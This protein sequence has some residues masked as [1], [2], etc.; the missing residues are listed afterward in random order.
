MRLLIITQKVDL[1][2]SALGFFH[3]WIEALAEKFAFI[4]VICLGKGHYNLPA[5]V[6]VYSLGKEEGLSRLKYIWRFYK[7]IWR[8]KRDYD[9]VFVH[10][11]PEY[12]LLGGLLWRF[13][14][15]VIGLWYVHKSVNIK[16]RIAEKLSHLIFSASRESFRLPSYK[17]RILGHAIDTDLFAPA[18]ERKGDFQRISLITAGRI[19]PIKDYETL[20]AA[21]EMLQKRGVEIEI[22]IIG[23]PVLDKDR[24]Y[25]K[26]LQRIIAE[27][28]LE[29]A[30]N[31]LGETPHHNIPDFLREA[32]IFI[33]MS[34]TGSVDKSVLEA[35]ACAVPVL[36][37]NEA[38]I[39]DVLGPYQNLLSYPAGNAGALTEKIIFLNQ[40]PLTERETLC[41]ELRGIVVLK[42]N[43]KQVIYNIYA[44]FN[45]LYVERHRN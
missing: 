43:M 20:I 31:F 25:L 9:V 5:N 30:I 35:M 45:D 7:Y 40:M 17:L 33:H 27:K 15:K 3:R 21:A 13:W 22:K 28:K 18:G 16:L 42:H 36:T 2:D 12:V 24:F 26:K 41:K 37:S 32:D 19:A 39:K 38:V 23:G 10:M 34:R 1:D 6:I 44:L 8:L 4:K 29:A 14:R 11:N